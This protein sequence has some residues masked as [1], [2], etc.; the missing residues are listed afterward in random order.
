MCL[1]RV[2]VT[3]AAVLLLVVG[4][5]CVEVQPRALIIQFRPLRVKP[6]KT[7]FTITPPRGGA[8]RTGEPVPARSKPVPATASRTLA[9]RVRAAFGACVL[10]QEPPCRVLVA[11]AHA[12]VRVRDPEWQCLLRGCVWSVWRH[13]LLKA[14]RGTAA[15]LHTTHRAAWPAMQRASRRGV[16]ANRGW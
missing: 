12:P 3:C 14:S 9:R 1:V 2:S 8:W 15:L 7:L 4:T 11:S 16:Y 6:R 10:A 13:G 5:V